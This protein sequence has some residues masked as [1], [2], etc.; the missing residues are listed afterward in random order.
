MADSDC[1]KVFQNR[2]TTFERRSKIIKELPENHL[3]YIRP[4]AHATMHQ[5]NAQ[6]CKYDARMPR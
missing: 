2:P 3:S 1:H 5:Y 6:K 4:Y